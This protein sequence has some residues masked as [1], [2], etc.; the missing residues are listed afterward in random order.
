MT[1]EEMAV[2]VT[3]VEHRAK[4]NTRR[5]EKLEQTTDA[6]HSLAESIAVLV[7]EQQNQTNTMNGIKSDVAKL[8]GKVEALEKKP[9]KRWEAT[10]DII[11]KI[12]VTAI[13]GL[14]LAKIGLG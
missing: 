6:I 10:V 5:I 3:E 9:G 1:S 13:V 12:V 14:V 7:N 11:F 2:K 4:S 8:D